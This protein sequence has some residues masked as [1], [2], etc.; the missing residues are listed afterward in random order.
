MPFSRHIAKELKSFCLFAT[1]F[2]ELTGLADIVPSVSNLHVS[3][4]TLDGSLTLL[5]KVKPGNSQAIFYWFSNAPFANML[6]RIER[7]CSRCTFSLYY[8][9]ISGVCDQSFGIH[10]AELAHFPQNVIEVYLFIQWAR[11]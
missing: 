1:H 3:A 7:L 6:R 11:I 10:V 5:Y 4:M 9:I 8:C 2:H